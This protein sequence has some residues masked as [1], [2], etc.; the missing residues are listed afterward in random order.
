MCTIANAFTDTEIVRVG[1]I[2][3]DHLETSVGQ[4]TSFATS[5]SCPVMPCSTAR[6]SSWGDYTKRQKSYAKELTFALLVASKGQSRFAL[7]VMEGS[8]PVA[9]KAPG[10]FLKFSAGGV[11]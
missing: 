3:G 8:H 11:G 2:L 10:L 6:S 9:E 5:F 7:E 4:D 1:S